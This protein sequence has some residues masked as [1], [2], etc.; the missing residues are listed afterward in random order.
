MKRKYI[1]VMFLS[2][3]IC[4]VGCQKQGKAAQ[5]FSEQNFKDLFIYSLNEFKPKDYTC[6][7][8]TDMLDPVITALPEEIKIDDRKFDGIDGDQ[9]R[10]S[11]YTSYYKSKEGSILIRI[12]Y[13]YEKTKK[14]VISISPVSPADPMNLK[15]EYEGTKRPYF[16]NELFGFGDYMVEIN[17]FL[18][19]PDS[20]KSPDDNILYLILQ[21]KAFYLQLEDCLLQFDPTKAYGFDYSY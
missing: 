18:V 15:K 16:L 8:Y 21:A 10:P 2:V 7:S 12:D 19:E 9:Q 1:L 11:K 3:V 14:G 4:F 5:T 6:L 20:K 17:S 13:I